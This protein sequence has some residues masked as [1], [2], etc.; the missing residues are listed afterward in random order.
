VLT[1][2]DS[3][4]RLIVDGLIK[5]NLLVRFVYSNK[6]EEKNSP[7]EKPKFEKKV[8]YK[9]KSS[10]PPQMEKSQSYAE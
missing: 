5:D 6:N 3:A 2:Y 10:K 9:E 8:T 7:V 1:D 4:R